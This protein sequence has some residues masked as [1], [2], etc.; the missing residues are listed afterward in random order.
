MGTISMHTAS[1]IGAFTS[2]RA[3]A[4]YKLGLLK[5]PFYAQVCPKMLEEQLEDKLKVY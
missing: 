2:K 5:R 4:R 1:F 3:P